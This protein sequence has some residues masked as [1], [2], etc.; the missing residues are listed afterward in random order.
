M[1]RLSLGLA[2]EELG[3]LIVRLFRFRVPEALMLL[4]RAADAATAAAA[5]AVAF[6]GALSINP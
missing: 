6:A 1:A 3:V 2:D 5:A 4:L